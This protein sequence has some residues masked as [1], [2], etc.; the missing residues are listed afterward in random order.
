MTASQIKSSSSSSKST[1][2]MDLWDSIRKLMELQNKAPEL[3][4]ITRDRPLAL[5][6]AQERLWLLEQLNPNTTTYNIPRQNKDNR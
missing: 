4:P 5:S 2:S 3:K 1:T 6:F